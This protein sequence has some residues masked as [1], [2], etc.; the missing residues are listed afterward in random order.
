[1]KRYGK[2]RRNVSSI[3]KRYGKYRRKLRISTTATPTATANRGKYAA[4][5]AAAAIALKFHPN[6]ENNKI[7]D[8]RKHFMK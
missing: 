5:A 8:K 6:T 4:V 7:S 3:V 2:Y 1:V